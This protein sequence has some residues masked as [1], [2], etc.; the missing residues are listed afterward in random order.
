VGAHFARRRV[1]AES[2]CDGRMG[3]LCT[4][5]GESCRKNG[6]QRENG[7]GR[8]SAERRALGGTVR[9]TDS[10]LHGRTPPTR[11]VHG[12]TAP[13]RTVL[14]SLPWGGLDG[15]TSAPTRRTACSSRPATLSERM[16][17]CT[18]NRCGEQAASKF[19]LDVLVPGVAIILSRETVSPGAAAPRVRGA[20]SGRSWRTRRV[21]WTAKCFREKLETCALEF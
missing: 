6:Q 10:L 12:R 4:C 7:G 21:W 17:G 1:G 18:S 8:T 20:L 3:E 15:R 5:L 19:R 9:G 11:T 16:A 14:D 13:P 2:G